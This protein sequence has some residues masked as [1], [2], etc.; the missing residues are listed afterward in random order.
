MQYFTSVYL[1]NLFA[2]K[3][4]PKDLSWLGLDVKVRTF[5]IAKWLTDNIESVDLISF[6]Q[7]LQ[8][9]MI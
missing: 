5:E 6:N 2:T 3:K 7:K 1:T 4:T 9:I 8:T